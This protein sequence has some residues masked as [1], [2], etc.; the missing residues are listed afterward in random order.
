M[1]IE[2]GRTIDALNPQAGG[3]PVLLDVDRLIETRLLLQANSGGG[4][5]RALRRILEQSFGQVQHLVI[6]PEGEFWTLR[7]KFDYVL[8]GH[9]REVPAT[10][11][12]AKQLAL[13][14]LEYRV[15][16]ILDI[17]ELDPKDRREFVARFVNALVNAPR[18]LWHKT[19]V[20]IDEA[21]VYAPEKK[22]GKSDDDSLAAIISLASRGRK[23]QF[24]PLLATQRISKLHK[25]AAAEC[26]NKLIGRAV[27]DLDIRRAADELGLRPIDRNALREL[28]PGE[29]F[30]FGPAL[31]HQMERVQI[32]DV[33]T[34]HLSGATIGTG[35]PKPPSQA[36]MKAL[37]RLAKVE[38]DAKAEQEEIDRLRG[39]VRE[40]ETEQRDLRRADVRV[41]VDASAIEKAVNAER[42]RLTGWHRRTWDAEVKGIRDGL[43]RARQY[44]SSVE[45]ELSKLTIDLKAMK[46]PNPTTTPRPSPQAAPPRFQADSNGAA[47]GD[48]DGLNSGAVRILQ[49]LAARYPAGYTKSQLGT[50]SRFSPNGGT[51]R[52]YV[53]HLKTRGLIEQSAN[54]WT[55]TEAGIAALGGKV[56]DAPR[57]H[58][59]ALEQWGERLNAG[60]FKM[61]QI[62]AEAGEE[63]VERSELAIL[64]GFEE[65]GG[66]FRTYVSHLTRNG[67]AQK[68]GSVLVATD[69][70]W[71]S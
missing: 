37:G 42:E 25:D 8:A 50:L 56:P 64:S 13:S 59:E 24:A 27:Q 32:G 57:T 70:L 31:S 3:D 47:P 39:R 21:H 63:G 65:K 12:T 29:F 30:A 11:N 20:V 16:A 18:A 10:P 4:K 34:R 5:T 26:N 22:A 71:P 51:F 62:V 38:D 2:V 46:T 17:Y 15:S 53:S 35:D 69:I 41:A 36:I 48:I 61:L 49:E 19:L 68:R 52:T 40:L 14:L 23:R 55:A 66:T 43:T 67:L 33:Q 7:D 45:L 28:K 58:E 44:L 60:A 6:D 9:G 1:K 54:G